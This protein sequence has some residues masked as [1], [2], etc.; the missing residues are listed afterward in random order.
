MANC[1]RFPLNPPRL[2]AL[3][4]DAYLT[5]TT[6]FPDP[7]NL[8]G[9][10]APKYGQ[11]IT[12]GTGRR[13]PGGQDVGSTPAVL[14]PKM[15]HLLTT[16]ASGDTTGMARRLFDA[17]LEDTCR[18]VAYF[19]DAALNAAAAVH[20]NIT[21]FCNAALSAPGSPQRSV[22]PVRIHQALKN[23]NWDITRLIAPTDLG[24]PAFNEGHKEFSTGDFNNG[25]GVMING[26]QYV[27]VL[28]THYRLDP[29][30]R[31]YCLTLK[32][33]FYDVFGL[34]DDDLREFGA[35]SDSM[36]SSKAAIGITAWWQ[37]QHQ[38]EYTPLVTRIIVEKTF[39]VPAT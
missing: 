26:V 14:K 34:D 11:D 17:F 18:D 33:I 16:F 30:T 9:L 23:A 6:P 21:Y 31:R 12:S 7:V 15:R 25:L 20:P 27:Y 4:R 32:F 19:E 29:A 13:A 28:A 39:D 24:V 37:L 22:G 1:S 36:L 3:A 38:H 8:P 2:V 35:A 10:P 5:P